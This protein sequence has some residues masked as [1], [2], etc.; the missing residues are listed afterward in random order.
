M[1]CCRPATALVE[2]QK[3][4]D[5]HRAIGC[6]QRILEKL[7]VFGGYQP[8][9]KKCTNK[10][11]ALKFSSE[12][13]PIDEDHTCTFGHTPVTALTTRT[14]NANQR[15]HKIQEEE[16]ADPCNLEITDNP[17]KQAQ[18]LQYDK[19]S[20]LRSCNVT[21]M[22]TARRSRLG[23][24]KN[25]GNLQKGGGPGSSDDG[26]F[27]P[28]QKPSMSRSMSTNGS[29]DTNCALNASMMVSPGFN[30]FSSKTRSTRLKMK[31]KRVSIVQTPVRARQC[32]TTD[33]NTFSMKKSDAANQKIVGLDPDLVATQSPTPPQLGKKTRSRGSKASSM[34]LSSDGKK[35]RSI[36]S[37]FID[38]LLLNFDEAMLNT[39]H[40][41]LLEP[42]QVIQLLHRALPLLEA[43]AT[44]TRIE[45]PCK[46][47]GDIHGQLGDLMSL[48]KRFGYPD[49][50]IGDIAF[51]KYVFLGDFVDR[52]HKCLEIMCLLLALKIKYPRRVFLIRGNHECHAMNEMYGFY[53]EINDRLHPNPDTLKYLETDGNLVPNDNF[54]E[55][56]DDELNDY[57]QRLEEK[58][59][60]RRALNK[61]LHS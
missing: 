58:R 48:F 52:G 21:P 1:G 17:S 34:D 2:G 39:E 49:A 32:L 35:R 59:Q 10:L 18:D 3:A 25:I 16:N 33:T 27:E 19:F 14:I 13:C 9:N 44:L 50:N 41:F 26:D 4:V 43:D 20:N 8:Q 22:R 29:R 31:K 5:E 30:S 23:K 61:Q 45:A 47:F 56:M 6:N 53:H 15:L 38:K 57:T 11:F 36:H 51:Y 55:Q 42:H 28:I 12:A 7:F 37:L 46:V 60:R 40:P 54:T 24:L